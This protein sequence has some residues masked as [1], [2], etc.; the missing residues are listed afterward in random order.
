MLQHVRLKP[1]ILWVIVKVFVSILVLT[2]L[3]LLLHQPLIIAPFAASCGLLFSV[4]YAIPATHM[5][6]MIVGHLLAVVIGLVF[7]HVLPFGLWSVAI[8][9]AVSVLLMMWTHNIHPP[10]CATTVVVVVE[11]AKLFFIVEVAVTVL[12]L[13]G[14]CFVFNCANKWFLKVRSKRIV[15]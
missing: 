4:P 11:H 2:K 6:N 8:A 13:V 15:M 10:A 7:V 3:S 12:T 14:L 5:R 9:A 1:P